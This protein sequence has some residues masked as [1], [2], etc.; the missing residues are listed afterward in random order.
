MKK[1]FNIIIT[2]VGGQGLITILRILAEAGL[3]QGFDVKASELHGLSQRE[4]S[5]STHIRFG[6][7]AR[8]STELSQ[9]PSGQGSK[10]FSPLIMKGKA[11]LILA[12]E[13]CEALRVSDFA[14]K[15]TVF[16]AN[17][18]FI[19]YSD[20]PQEKQVLRQ[21]ETIPGK[22]CF[23]DA[24]KICQK[25]LKTEVVVGVYL[26]GY[27]ASDGLLPLEEKSLLVAIKKLIPQKYFSSNKKA[28]ELGQNHES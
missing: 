17:K 12:L 28:F 26:L 20:G 5:V 9:M 11:D 8:T 25:K 18:K 3:L 19:P 6:P 22:K 2:G 27:A 14:N 23:I 10:V 16:L 24:S 7:S 21:L 4:G 1:E 15:N 13:V